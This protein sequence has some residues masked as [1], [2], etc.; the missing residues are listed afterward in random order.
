MLQRN[1]HHCNLRPGTKEKTN[2]ML[3]A[4]Q[5]VLLVINIYR[6]KLNSLQILSNRDF[7]SSL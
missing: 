2:N 6:N 7:K 4:P 3:P 5:Q 1:V